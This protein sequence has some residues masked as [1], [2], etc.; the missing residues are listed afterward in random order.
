MEFVGVGVDVNRGPS[1]AGIVGRRIDVNAV[2]GGGGD[3]DV[4][5]VDHRT[6]AGHGLDHEIVSSCRNREPT[7]DGGASRR[8]F[9]F[10]AVIPDFA[11]IDGWSCRNSVGAERKQYS[12]LAGIVGRLGNRDAVGSGDD[13]G[14]VLLVVDETTRAHVLDHQL[15]GSGGK[16]EGLIDCG[17]WEVPELHAGGIVPNLEVIDGSA[18]LE[19]GGLNEDV[20][21]LI[22]IVGR[23]VNGDTTRGRG[24]E[25]GHIRRAVGSSRVGVN[26]EGVQHGAQRALMLVEDAGNVG[27]FYVRSDK[28]GVDLS[29]HVAVSVVEGYE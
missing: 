27:S 24:E 6:V 15:V 4:G 18:V 2:V 21:T 19:G 17:A 11:M 20:R 14:G 29:L 25:V 1:L 26:A 9:E 12:R 3:V 5:C 7:I 22:G 23:R 28:R 16:G 13:S 8:I 10:A